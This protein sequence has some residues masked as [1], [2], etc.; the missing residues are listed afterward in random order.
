MFGINSN[1]NRRFTS[2]SRKIR[3]A[4]SGKNGWGEVN[5]R[6]DRQFLPSFGWE[7]RAALS[8]GRNVE[9][10]LEPRAV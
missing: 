10:W 9:K 8:G 4:G 1:T 7:I 2:G 6:A 3:L 5:S